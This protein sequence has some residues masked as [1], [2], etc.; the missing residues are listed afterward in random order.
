MLHSDLLEGGCNVGL[1]LC[2]HIEGEGGPGLYVHAVGRL[3]AGERGEL[4]LH[5]KT[6]HSHC[7]CNRGAGRQVQD[8]YITATATE[9]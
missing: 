7:L 4:G 9:G 8:K 1:G 3:G 5:W 2:V 6:A